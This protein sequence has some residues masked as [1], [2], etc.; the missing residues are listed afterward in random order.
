MIILL[1][2][3]KSGTTSFN[4]LFENLGYKSYHW[5]KQKKYIGKMIQDNKK[6]GKPL[7]SDFLDT[8]VITQMDVCVNEDN[9]Y[10]PQILD[11]K[12]IISENPNSIFILNKRNPEEIL[13]SFERWHNKLDAPMCTQF[14]KRLFK[15]N[16]EIIPEKTDKA[17]IEFVNKFYLEIETYFKENK[18]I[19]FIS[20]DINNDKI[21]KLNKYID[22]K[23]T[24][25]LP[26]EN[27]N[28]KKL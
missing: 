13:D 21:E 27:V 22:I 16:P 25:A 4:V 6:N 8:D 11:Y 20:Y 5:K 24:L 7:L 10:W 19:K 17:F 9:C 18:N 15:Y 2:L 3:P 23:E 14:K 1:G 26:R 28:K 12:Q